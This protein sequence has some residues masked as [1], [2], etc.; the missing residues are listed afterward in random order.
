MYSLSL[1]LSV[2]KK[3]LDQGSSD[4][5]SVSDESD[6]GVRKAANSSDEDDVRSDVS[7]DDDD[8]LK[9]KSKSTPK[10]MPQALELGNRR[11]EDIE[12][13]QWKSKV[14]RLDMN[15]REPLTLLRS[16]P[17][18]QS[19]SDIYKLKDGN[20]KSS[21]KVIGGSRDADVV[22]QQKASQEQDEADA[23][24]DDEEDSD[25]ADEDGSDGSSEESGSDD[26]FADLEQH[27]K[28][29]QKQKQ[30]P[31]RLMLA[32]KEIKQSVR[33]YS[34]VAKVIV[35]L[36][37][38]VDIVGKSPSNSSENDDYDEEEVSGSKKKAC[39][40]S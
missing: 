34:D 5:I 18:K 32:F 11:A 21:S 14:G 20:Q 29:K 24:S 37:V 28:K 38:A 9:N 16:S 12:F 22:D 25:E 6:R 33:S 27:S 19:R 40:I 2:D 7:F 39:S 15:V 26:S 35:E 23:S 17:S 4:D 13:E 31:S 8:P 36:P 3:F 30:P 10:F 1:S